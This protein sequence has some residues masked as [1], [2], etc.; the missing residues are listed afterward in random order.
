[1]LRVRQ[2]DLVITLAVEAAAVDLHLRSPYSSS[3]EE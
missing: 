2:P 3:D 1:M